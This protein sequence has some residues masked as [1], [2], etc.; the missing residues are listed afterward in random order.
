LD[1]RDNAR[2][3]TVTEIETVIR[4]FIATEMGRAPIAE[5]QV[6]TPMLENDLLDSVGVYEVVVFLE[7]HYGIE[8]LDEEM[9]PENFG[10]ISSLAKLVESKR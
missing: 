9:V 6:D 7:E 10:T 5:L 2:D 3:I 4:D 1:A 8:I